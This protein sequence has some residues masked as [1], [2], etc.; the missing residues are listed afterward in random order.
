MSQPQRVEKLKA[1][2]QKTP[3]DPFLVYALGME[4]RHHDAAEAI[5]LFKRVIELDP[6]HAYAYFQLGQTQE[7]AGDAAA[8]RAA[9]QAGLA[10][11]Q[12]AGDAHAHGEISAALE[13][14]G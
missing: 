3:N 9:Y 2:L 5:T 14:L 7:R 4:R 6:A 10:A 11:A 13:A 8:A 12:R 1:M